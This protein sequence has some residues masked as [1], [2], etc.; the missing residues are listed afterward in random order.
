MQRL[1]GWLQRLPAKTACKDCL[2]R[3]PAKTACRVPDE[4]VPGPPATAAENDHCKGWLQRLRGCKDCVAAKTACKGCRQRPPAESRRLVRHEAEVDAAVSCCAA[5]GTRPAPSP[6]LAAGAPS[7]GCSPRQRPPRQRPPRRRPPRRRP[8]RPETSTSKSGTAA[9][10]PRS[11]R[12]TPRSAAA[13]SG[14]TGTGAAP[15]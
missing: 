12:W 14:C 11:C 15:I 3:L 8:P 4:L 9:R 10:G 6:P 13:P 2:Q 5:G 1:P 7:S